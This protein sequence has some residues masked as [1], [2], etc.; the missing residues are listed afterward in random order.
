MKKL[1]VTLSIG[2]LAATGFAGEA[3]AQPGRGKA[4]GHYKH[5][6][7]YAAPARGYYVAPR[8]RSNGSAVAAGVAGAIIGGALS[9]TAR[10]SY[11]YYEQPAYGYYSAPRRYYRD[12]YYDDY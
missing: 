1:A 2:L 12:D 4:Y 7:R 11:R 6:H 3:D 10:P 9:A 8:R 5:A